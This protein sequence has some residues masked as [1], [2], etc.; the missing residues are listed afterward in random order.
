ML[1]GGA[2]LPIS[3]KKTYVIEYSEC[4][5]TLSESETV[6]QARQELDSLIRSEF[7]DADVIKMRTYGEFADGVY[8]ITTRV[9][10]SAD[11][12]KESTIEIN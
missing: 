10:Y 7:K 1:F 5:R 12:G 6:S 3:L 2:E 8:R 11:I 9:V 4:T